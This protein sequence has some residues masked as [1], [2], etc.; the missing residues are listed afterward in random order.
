M[1]QNKWDCV[2]NLSAKEEEIST[3]SNNIMQ[4]IFDLLLQY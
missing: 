2:M 3:N 1:I 4:Q